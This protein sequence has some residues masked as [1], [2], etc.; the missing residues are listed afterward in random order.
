MF[1]FLFIIYRVPGGH[2]Q[3]QVWNVE[4]KAVIAALGPD[5]WATAV[6]EKKGV[7]VHTLTFYDSFAVHHKLMSTVASQS[8]LYPG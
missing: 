7:T 4:K 5:H 6:A 3:L 2:H 1:L 8:S